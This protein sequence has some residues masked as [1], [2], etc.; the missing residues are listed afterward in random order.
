MEETDISRLYEKIR[1][2]EEENRLLKKRLQEAGISFKDL[3]GTAKAAAAPEPEEGEGRGAYPVRTAPG[4]SPDAG[5]GTGIRPFEVTEKVANT[6]FMMFCRGRKDVYEKRYT[7][8]RTGKTGYYVQCNNRWDRECHIQKKDGVRCRDCQIRAYTE[9]TP[10]TVKEH[11]EGKD[12]YGNDVVAIYPMLENNVCQLLV[13]DFDNHEKG[14]EQTDHANT[15][16]TWMEEVDA[17]RKICKALGVGALTERSRS[18]R[19]AHVWIFFKEMV[20][21]GLARKFGFALLEKGAESIDL[22]SFGYYDRMIPAQDALPKGGLGNVIA[23]PLQGLALKSGNSAFVDE[24]W[25]AYED[26]LKALGRVKRLT[27]KEIEE[28][29]RKWYGA[30]A[31]ES[32]KTSD[33][34][35]DVEPWKRD[36]AFHRED[37][38]GTVSIVLSDRIYVDASLLSSRLRRQIRQLAAFSNRQFFINQAMDQYGRAEPRYIYLGSDEGKYI[39]LP[40]GLFEDLT[41]GFEKA[42]IPYCVEDKRTGG[43]QI[44]VRF[45]GEL[46]EVQRAAADALQKHDTG[47]LHAATAFGKTVVCCD[48]IAR[49]GV[50]TLILVEKT[51]LMDQWVSR[52]EEFLEIEEELPEYQTKTGRVRKRKKLIGSLQGSRDTLTGIVDVAMVRSVKSKDGFHP[53]LKKYGMVILDECHHAASASAIEV[54][55]EVRARYVCG[56]TATLKRGDGKERINEYLLGPVRYRYTAKD[57]A[58]EQGTIRRVYPRF[59]KTVS[60][61]RLSRTPYDNEAFELI[62][63]NPVRDAQIIRDVCECVKAGRTPVILTKFVDHAERL[64]KG[65]QACAD[66]VILLTGKKESKERKDG[67]GELYKTDPSESLILVGTGSLLGEGFDYHRLD[68][69][70]MADPVSGENVVTQY[71]GRIDRDYDGKEDMT[72][73][74]YVDSHIGKFEKMFVSRIKAYKKIGYEICSGSV[75]G[76]EETGAIFDIDT[77]A[78]LYWKDLEGA[79]KEIVISSPG[80]NPAKVDQLIARIGK[81]QEERNLKV[82]AVT[83]HPD[84]GPYGREDERMALMEQLR[85]A[86]I[87]VI[88]TEEIC[89]RYTVIDREV[90]WYGS[91]N[92]LAKEDIDDNLIRLDSREIAAELLEMTFGKESRGRLESWQKE[93]DQ[94]D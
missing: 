49:R 40:R 83:R 8:P 43:K 67:I 30:G 26:Q 16:R 59:T 33:E 54:L 74:D 70:F 34:K 22:K 12:P 61:H 71:A 6:F 55:Q 76:K 46:K 56:V 72:I 77:Y 38:G 5:Q 4:T 48:L 9:L 84:A 19:G 94:Q 10:K 62:R 3:T 81:A 31:E 82:F 90:V 60:P 41:A 25:N 24:N 32:Q 42:G 93:Q 65:L 85:K 58:R 18:G 15:G 75:G 80:M 1:R 21:A 73:Y 14:S 50:N 79:G 44:C 23:L 11:M 29:I 78:E 17:L 47:I 7:N 89:E 64:Y 88:L 66:R 53:F 87:E 68:T 36:R 52:L 20:P 2:L 91:V 45:R 63:N 39:V 86:G 51:D 28:Y 92:F 13:F 57:R 37:A 35:A 69:L 27:R